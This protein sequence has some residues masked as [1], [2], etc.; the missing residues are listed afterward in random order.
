MIPQDAQ[1]FSEKLAAFVG[2]HRRIVADFGRSLANAR[3]FLKLAERS[4]EREPEETVE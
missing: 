4:L 3:H 2:T 1:E